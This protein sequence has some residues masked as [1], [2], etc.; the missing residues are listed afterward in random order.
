MI[1]T[2]DPVRYTTYDVA[3]GGRL[4]WLALQG[5]RP[6]ADAAG[7]VALGERLATWGA[8]GDVRVA[9]LEF[10]GEA[11]S[12]GNRGARG[13]A[14]RARE[15]AALAWSLHGLRMPTI[16]VARGEVEGAAFGLFAGCSHRMVIE[17]TWLSIGDAASGGLPCAGGSFFAHRMP[18]ASGRFVALSAIALNE[19]DALYA[20]I[21]DGFSAAELLED[22]P[23]ALVDIAWSADPHEARQAATRWLWSWHRRCRAGLPS[24]PIEQYAD[25]IRF[26]AAQPKLG[27]LAAALEAAARE[28]PWFKPA[29]D[30]LRAAAAGRNEAIDR[31]LGR[32]RWASLNEA[33]GLEVQAAG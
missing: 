9:V 15:L 26:I 19:A 7:C 17:G 29:L 21:G 28:D 3:G 30:A 27:S 6:F 22:M 4:A 12:P 24:A 18:M 10:A 20:G 25:A 14:D 23:Q 1:D 16:G 11:A 5:T 13:S 31:L 2:D 32:S 8:A 33:L